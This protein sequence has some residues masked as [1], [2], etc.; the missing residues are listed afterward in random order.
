MIRSLSAL[1][2]VVACNG[3]P[4]KPLAEEILGEWEV[5]CSTDKESTATCLGKED[6]GLYK[7]FRAG[8][9]LV[10]GAR[11][12]ISMNGTWTLTDGELVLAFE[13]GG[14]RLREAYRARIEDG[15]LVL[16]YPSQGFGSVLGRAGAPFE[17]AASKQS[18]DGPTSHA[19][20]GVSYTLALPLG[21]R[22]ARDDN[23]RQQ[24]SPS[25]GAGF[26]VRLTVSPRAQ[27]RV[28]G[29]W[30]TLPCNEEDYGGVS[31]SRSVIDGV[32]R[33]TSIGLSVCLDGRDQVLM[34]SAGHTRGYLEDVE[35]DAALALCRSLVV[36]Q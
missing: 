20:G 1:V 6:Q 12:G 22:L 2:L 17:P 34:C 35:R 9:K 7:S 11:Q 10:S 28:D 13:G 23:D 29:K 18:A 16:W 24:W 25:S 14:L 15:R 32:E 33:G 3:G 31:S 36:A 8:G 21:Y 27:R 26:T 4:S 19:I 5:L 30:A